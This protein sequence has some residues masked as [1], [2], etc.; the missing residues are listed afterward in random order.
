MG[1][2]QHLLRN[3]QRL[4]A[5]VRR[6]CRTNQDILVGQPRLLQL[7][8]VFLDFRGRREVLEFDQLAVEQRDRRVE[9][10]LAALHF[11]L[12]ADLEIGLRHAL[13][14]HAL[15]T[16]FVDRGIKV[17]DLCQRLAAEHAQRKSE[18]QPG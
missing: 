7:Q 9:N 4:A 10:F 13:R 14:Q 15:A 2:G 18:Q 6:G 11:N 3:L 16:R 1:Q 5:V 8:V 17:A 12:L